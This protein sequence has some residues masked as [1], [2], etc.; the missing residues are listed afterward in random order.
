MVS[1]ECEHYQVFGHR[2]EQMLGGRL[3]FTNAF[4]ADDVI[5]GDF[6][7]ETEKQRYSDHGRRGTLSAEV[8]IVL[9][10]SM[11]LAHIFRN[12]FCANSDGTLT[13]F[14]RSILIL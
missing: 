5:D 10:K 11:S 4:W 8:I 9:S 7:K 12:G 3:A 6:V 13:I 1:T 2:F 14:R